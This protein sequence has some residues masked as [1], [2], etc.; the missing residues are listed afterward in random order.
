MGAGRNETKKGRLKA[1][2][3]KY[4]L[5]LWSERSSGSPTVWDDGAWG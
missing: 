4:F 5:W 2:M 3:A 1:N